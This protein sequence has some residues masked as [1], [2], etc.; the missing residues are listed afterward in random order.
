MLYS[1]Q[2]PINCA[3]SISTRRSCSK[4]LVKISGVLESTG[5][6]PPICKASEKMNCCYIVCIVYIFAS[7][8]IN[9]FSTPLY[10]GCSFLLFLWTILWRVHLFRIHLVLFP[11]WFGAHRGGLLKGSLLAM[12]RNKC[13]NP[14]SIDKW[15]RE[16]HSIFLFGMPKWG[17]LL[18]YTR[19]VDFLGSW[20]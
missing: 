10:P 12:L 6:I 9:L 20:A 18:V 7:M 2:D 3:S 11:S 4:S 19:F 16:G 1:I 13:F 14:F 8:S 5:N 17:F 15:K